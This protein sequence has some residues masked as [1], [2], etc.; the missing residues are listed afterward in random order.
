MA[1]PHNA[2]RQ[3]GR[4]WQIT[5][6]LNIDEDALFDGQING[7]LR[8]TGQLELGPNARVAGTV[9]GQTVRVAGEVEADIVGQQEVEML[10]GSK[11]RGR[12]YASRF[13]VNEGA[14]FRGE[15][16]CDEQAM[17]SAEEEVLS[18]LGREP[19]S[20]RQKTDGRLSADELASLRNG[21]RGGN[22]LRMA[23]GGNGNGN[24]NGR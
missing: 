7:V 24:G 15:I 3:L 11:M 9:V 19:G 12:V 5:G 13:V 21:G 16:I 18:Q 17:Q 22:G 1:D 14:G 6:E 10:P 23:A 4:G 8:V 20:A 2:P